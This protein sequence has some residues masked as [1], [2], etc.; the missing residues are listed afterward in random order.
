MKRLIRGDRHNVNNAPIHTVACTIGV[1][2][3]LPTTVEEKPEH[4]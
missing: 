1:R 2:L 3:G 4:R